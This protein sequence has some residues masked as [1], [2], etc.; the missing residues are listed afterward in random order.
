MIRAKLRLVRHITT[1]VVLLGLFLCGAEVGVRV[2]ELVQGQPVCPGGATE[3]LTDPS[4]LTVPSWMTNVELKPN[5]TAEVRCR[6]Q[7]HAVEIQTNS[8]GFR[9]PELAVPKPQETYRIVVLGDETIFA[10]ETSDGD[11]FVQQLADLLQQRTRLKIEVVN[12]GLPGAC[13]LTEFLLFK[14][15]LL[16]AQPDLVLLHYD[17]SDVADDRQLRRRM[18]SDSQ[19]TPLSCPH[20]SLQ[21]TARKPHPFDHLRQQFRLV[22][23]GLIAAGKQWKQQITEN[24]AASREL[25]TN[26]YAWMREEHPESDVKVTH[27]FRPIA[28]IARL[29]QGTSFQLVLATSP[30]PWQVSARCTNGPGIRLRC[31]VSAD[32]YYPN[33]APFD[34]LAAYAGELRLP[35]ID[36]SDALLNVE[37]P[38][39]NYLRF[40]PRWS[41]AGHRRVAEFLAAYL[42]D[43]IPGPWNSRYFQHDE[44][45]AQPLDRVPTPQNEIQWASGTR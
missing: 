14:R 34:A 28:E 19:G 8:L 2:Y 30:K 24:A 33:R 9:G 36:L 38:E 13:P 17:W 21:G 31:G 23:W 44:Q 6:D 39:A 4:G 27:S 37:Q 40:A 12:A 11:H 41:A 7:K 35:Y 32:A 22:D 20:S 18:R 43:R 1:A 10:P 16:A 42:T 29:S 45:L 3:C 26:A 15:K 5:A 25:G